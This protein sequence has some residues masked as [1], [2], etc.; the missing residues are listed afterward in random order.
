MM[1]QVVGG[2]MEQFPCSI[3][4][5]VWES[6]SSYLAGLRCMS[7]LLR[8]LK[9]LFFCALFLPEYFQLNFNNFRQL[10][11]QLYWGR[12]IELLAESCTVCGGFLY[13]ISTES[14]AW[15]III[16]YHEA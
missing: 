12:L 3:N 8:L 5:E 1:S 9:L 13:S 15:P 7:P 11:C 10:E 2:F 14:S 4:H 6:P 16:V